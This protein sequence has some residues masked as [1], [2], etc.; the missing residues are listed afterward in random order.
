MELSSQ[1]RLR[2]DKIVVLTGR[3]WLMRLLQFRIELFL[4]LRAEAVGE[5]RSG[6]LADVF[7]NTLPIALV[8][9]YIFTRR[10]DG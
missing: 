2:P 4:A 7:F 3:L 5:F 9:S 1:G 6:A 8:V 10:T